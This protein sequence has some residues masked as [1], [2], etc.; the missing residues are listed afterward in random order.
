LARYGAGND[1]LEGFIKLV[2][3]HALPDIGTA[4]ATGQY[5]IGEVWRLRESSEAIQFRQWM[6]NI[7]ISDPSDVTAAYIAAIRREPRSSSWPVRTIRLAVTA[8]IGFIG[9]TIGLAAGGI[10]SFFVDKFIDGYSP[11]LFFNKLE[12]LGISSSVPQ[13][14][15]GVEG[16]DRR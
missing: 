8:A 16:L 11:K 1:V 15:P 2:D 4:V 7:P 12:R 5:P 9:T 6:R 10:D 13:P 3:L 14:T